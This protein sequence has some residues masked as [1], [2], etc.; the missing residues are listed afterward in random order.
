MALAAAALLAGGSI[1]ASELSRA[2]N[3]NANNVIPT[4]NTRFDLANMATQFDALNQLGF[5]DISSIPSPSQRLVD[6]INGLA[7][8]EKI[9]RRGLLGLQ[10]LLAGRAPRFKDITDDVLARVGLSPESVAGLREQDE[11]FK[12]QQESLAD[13][14][15]INTSTV[16]ERA[17]SAE[18]ASQ[19]IGSASR[20]AAG[21]DLSPLQK[22]LKQR[23]TRFLDDAEEQALLRG[24]FGGFNPASAL[25]GINDQRIDQ[26]LLAIEQSLQLANGITGAL[27]GGLASAQ[28][29]ANTSLNANLGALGIAA[30]QSAAANQINAQ[31]ELANSQ[32]RQSGIQNAF[33]VL[34]A[35][36]GGTAPASERDD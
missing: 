19:L 34:G 1:A 28:N 17:R 3:S 30:N 13:L 18:A 5:G 21:G 2:S 31:I 33:N 23:N 20:F 35:A 36:A 6:Q 29:S 8:D 9:K 25:E 26:D 27:G 24:Q 15:G 4:T 14:S 16:L 32:L 12:L 22:S 7:I 11:S 10:D